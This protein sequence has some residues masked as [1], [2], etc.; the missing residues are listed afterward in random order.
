MYILFKKNERYR[1]ASE[2]ESLYDVAIPEKWNK[3]LIIFSHGYMGYKDWGAWNLLQDVFVKEGFGFLK[4]NVSHNGGTTDEPIDFP[5][6][7]AFAENTYTKELADLEAILKIAAEIEQVQEICLLGHSRGGGIVLLQSTH[8]QVSKI[9]ALAPISSIEKRFPSGD[10]L[11]QWEKE[12]VRYITNGRTQQEMPHHFVQYEDYV[13][14]A[15]RLDIE[16]CA[17]NSRVPICVIHGEE[18]ASVHISEGEEIATWAGV[19]LIRIEGE[20]HTFGAQQPWNEKRL[21]LG[22]EKVVQHLRVFF[23]SN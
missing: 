10:T 15:E 21:P 17:R 13:A 7:D 20:Q 23:N 12:G 11:K 3:K 14:H 1:G 22:L 9:A 19:E 5:D 4:Y 18:D 8:P 2:R 16:R 6:L